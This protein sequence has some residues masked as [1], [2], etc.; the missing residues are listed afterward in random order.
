MFNYVALYSFVCVR[1]KKELKAKQAK[2]SMES[3][4]SVMSDKSVKNKAERDRSVAYSDQTVLCY[5]IV[6]A[7]I[8][9]SFLTLTQD[10]CCCS[11][12]HARLSQNT[13]EPFLLSVTLRRSRIFAYIIVEVF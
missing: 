11:V 12:W 1:E 6:S 4:K 8:T 2:H 5:C 7:S 3:V 13:L 10:C 9:L